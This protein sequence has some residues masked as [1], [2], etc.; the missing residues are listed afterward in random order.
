MKGKIVLISGPCGSG[1]TTVS[2]ILSQITDAAQA[3][4]MHT[5]DFYSYIKKGY[6]EPWK[7]GSGDQNETVI[8][9]AAA[10]AKAY[11]DGGYDVFVDGVIG[12]WFLD[13]WK[14]CAEQGED[15]RYVVLR[16]SREET[17]RRGLEREARAEFPLT[18]SVFTQMW[19][20]FAALGEYEAHAVMT[21]GQTAEETAAFVQKQL[22]GGA[23]RLPAYLE[24]KGD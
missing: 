10:C 17:V 14:A 2:R 13:I 4:H 9:A 11:A 7:D 23:F 5:D 24:E 15:I 21:D 19:D 20:M 22:A 6:I 18:E 16:P 3:V 12:P 8:G 1:K